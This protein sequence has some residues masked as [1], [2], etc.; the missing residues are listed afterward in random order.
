MLKI[1]VI[2]AD[3]HNPWYR[4]EWKKAAKKLGAKVSLIPMKDVILK[5]D[6]KKGVRA[7]FWVYDR[8]EK[9]VKVQD[10]KDYDILIR[11]WVSKFYIQSLVLGW[12]MKR[13][14]KVVLNSKLEM[15]LDKVSQAIRLFDAGLPHPL[16]WQ[17]LRP[18]N[19]KKLLNQIS[20]Y[21]IIIKPISGTMGQGV[22]KAKSK[23]GALKLVGKKDIHGLLIQRDLD[24]RYDLRIFVVGNR[25]LGAM[26]RM[27]PE[28]DFRSNVAVGA[29]T[30]KYELTPELEKLALK[31][32]RAMG[33][34]ICGVDIMFRKNKPYVLEVNRTP[35]F[36]GFTKTF[37]INVPEEI[38]KFA[39]SRQKKNGL[40]NLFRKTEIKFA[41]KAAT[42]RVEIEP[43]SSTSEEINLE[44]KEIMKKKKSLKTISKPVKF[45][46][47]KIQPVKESKVKPLPKFKKQTLGQI[48]NKSKKNISPHQISK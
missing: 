47:K 11:R 7:Q 8:K 13:L 19:A 40:S 21:P 34:E 15:I 17:A 18:R 30:E 29:T 24:I 14:G 35:Q 5:I 10:F 33:Y 46:K 23:S 26:K 36:R 3:A 20:S 41:P 31:A 12:Y 25:C 9:K 2:G 28:G 16:T 22:F 42:R 1:A 27:A 37:R 48:E 39:I 44:K 45:T 38:I 43:S 6:Q 32:A 4:K